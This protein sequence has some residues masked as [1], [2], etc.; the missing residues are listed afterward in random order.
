[1]P[2]EKELDN[3]ENF[4]KQAE[5]KWVDKYIYLSGVHEFLFAG[6]SLK[7]SFD[8]T[9]VNFEIGHSNKKYFD[10]WLS[11][12]FY[13][14]YGNNL[15]E[16]LIDEM[17][18]SVD[19]DELCDNA[20]TLVQEVI[21]QFDNQKNVNLNDVSK[22]LQ[23]QAEKM[24]MEIISTK[25]E[26]SIIPTSENAPSLKNQASPEHSLPMSTEDFKKELELAK[27]MGYVQG[28]CESVVVI[29][30]E[31]EIG[32]KVMNSMKVTKEMAEKYAAPE[33][34][35]AMEEGVFSQKQ[36]QKL[37]HKRVRIL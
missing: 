13:Q 19:I 1:M 22:Y 8:G 20:K 2:D 14:G 23:E 9:T 37:E 4:E 5:D 21:K 7:H 17:E 34:F 30:K 18:P 11:L 24:G 36:E 26:N 10:E 16:I 15:C 27:K 32:K 12:K 33:T 35:K 25:Q 6:E 31:Y 3:K 28:V 29:D